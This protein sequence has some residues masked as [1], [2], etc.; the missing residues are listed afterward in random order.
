MCT[1]LEYLRQNLAVAT[2]LAAVMSAVTALLAFIVSIA[3]VS[4][5]RATLKHQRAHN[6]LTF[7]PFPT[8]SFGD[9]EDKLV[10]WLENHGAGPMIIRTMRATR[11]PQVCSA[12]IE[13]MPKLLHGIT[14]TKF[15]GSIDGRAIVPNDD[16]T[17]IQLDGDPKDLAFVEARDAIREALAHV[18]IAVE[19][20]DM[21]ESKTSTVSR[22]L[23]WFGRNV[24][25]L[26]E[27][28]EGT[29]ESPQSRRDQLSRGAAI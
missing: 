5:A 13:L 15:V 28:R 26:P 4:V 21:Y 23:D 11:G 6:I 16:L 3:A 22:S 7:R 25:L 10:V 27:P 1:L 29:S 18:Y 2:S 12:L 9:Y 8:I 24:G 20:T 19:Y 17:L 14:W